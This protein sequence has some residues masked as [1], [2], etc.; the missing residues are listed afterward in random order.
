M[1][2]IPTVPEL[3]QFNLNF[4]KNIVKPLKDAGYDEENIFNILNITRQELRHSDFLAFLLNPHRSGDIGEQFLRN[5]LYLLTKQD[6]INYNFI[7][8]PYNSITNVNVYR[9]ITVKDGRID[10]LMDLIVTKE[11]PQAVVIVIENKVDSDQHDNQLGKY[12][13]FLYNS[14]Y[15]EYQ[16]I[17]LYLT[18]DSADSGYSEWLEINYE[19]IYNAL[20]QIDHTYAN[21]TV[22]MLINDYK[23]IIRSEFMNDSKA[24]QK[25]LEIYH[26]NPQIFDFIYNEVQGVQQGCIKKIS[27]IL[28][29]CLLAQE[30]VTIVKE[31]RKGELEVSCNKG[32]VN[33]MFRTTELMNYPNYYFQICVDKMSLLFINDMGQRVCQKKWLFVN[34]QAS[35]DAI[36]RFKELVVTDIKLLEA[37]CNQLIEQIFTAPGGAIHK[38]LAALKNVSTKAN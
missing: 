6:K 5:F 2:S 7:K 8:P 9:E 27:T 24:K 37:E 29:D 26:S 30:G 22:K 3:E 4:E 16:K 19:L 34:P 21:P 32:L 28:G 25:A 35:T 1:T 23:K 36:E 33:L 17:M 20:N 12:R 38:A 11:K 18:P 14:K 31:N 13:D 10:L 15:Q